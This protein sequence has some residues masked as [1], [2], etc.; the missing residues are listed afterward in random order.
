MTIPR[1]PAAATGDDVARAI[2][3]AG[4]AVVERVASPDI[5]AH[6]T[7]ELRPYTDAT[8]YGTDDF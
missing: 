4:C 8:P 2:A 3:E 1:L 5:L 6:L 7:A